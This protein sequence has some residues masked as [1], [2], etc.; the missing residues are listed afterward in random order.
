VLNLLHALTTGTHFLDRFAVRK[1]VKV[2]YLDLEL[3]KSLA[4]QWRRAMPGLNKDNFAYYDMVG[5]GSQLDLRS[6]HLR[7][8]WAQHFSDTGVELVIIDPMSCVYSPLGVDEH[9]PEVRSVLDAFDA[10]VA[11]TG[12]HGVVTTDHAGHGEDS[13]TRA[14][15]HSSKMDWLTT[16]MS[17]VRQGEDFEGERVFQTDGRGTDAVKGKLVLD[18]RTQMLTLEPT[19]SSAQNS[20]LSAQ[21]GRELTLDEA[22]EAMGLSERRA[23]T[24]LQNEGWRNVAGRNELGKWAFVRS[25]APLS[26]PFSGRTV[27][28]WSDA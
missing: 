28:H 20:W 7:R 4:Y 8:K 12:M 6:D 26:D 10:L 23:R 9:G 21:R 3:G 22:A 19:V 15:G 5:F 11:T 13:K 18:E 1:P 17:I 16:R 27:G 24:R 25:D 14:R 2:A